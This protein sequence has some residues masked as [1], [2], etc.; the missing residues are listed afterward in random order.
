[1]FELTPFVRGTDPFHMIDRME[2]EMFHAPRPQA[3]MFRTDIRDMGE[4]YLLEADFPGMSKED[5]SISLDGG[6]LTISASHKQEEEEKKENG[7]Y[8]RRERFTS[9]AS[10]SFDMTGIDQDG[11]TA[12]FENGVLSLTLPK[13]KET[14]PAARQISIA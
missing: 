10:R 9:F 3:A 12:S 14:V 8:I 5:I 11:I 6:Y 13:E 4:S 1:M 2:K 7:G